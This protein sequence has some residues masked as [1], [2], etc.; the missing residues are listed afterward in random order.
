GCLR[1]VF[2]DNP[3][4]VVVVDN[5]S[6]DGSAGTVAKM[7]RQVRVIENNRNRGFAAAANQGVRA[8]DSATVVLLNPDATIVRGSLAALEATMRAHPRAAVVGALVR[9]MDGS[10]QPT[11]RAF[12]SLWH[13]FL[14]ATVG[15]VWPNNP[16]TRAY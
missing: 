2:D 6:T 7:F 3:D 11:K 10:V 15:T 16:G 9:N 12:P 5:A 13:S 4:D 14:H 8:T 1:S